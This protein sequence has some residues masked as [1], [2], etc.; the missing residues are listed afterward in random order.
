MVER[1]GIE[2][3]K[4]KGERTRGQIAHFIRANDDPR[5][6]ED[7]TPPSDEESD[8]EAVHGTGSFYLISLELDLDP[9][10]SHERHTTKPAPTVRRDLRR[11]ALRS[12]RTENRP[13]PA[14]RAGATPYCAIAIPGVE[15]P[16]GLVRSYF[17]VTIRM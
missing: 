2:I 1:L 4:Q 12:S 6:L 5:I 13:R 11:D 8:H 9:V 15:I 10:A 16:T 14:N 7:L 17:L 3:V